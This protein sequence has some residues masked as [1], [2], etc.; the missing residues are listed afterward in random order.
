[1]EAINPKDKLTAA[2]LVLEFTKAK[3]AAQAELTVKRAEDYLADIAKEMI[4]DEDKS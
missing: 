1:M 2:R 3:P 4:I